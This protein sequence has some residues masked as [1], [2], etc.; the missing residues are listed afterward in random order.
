MFDELNSCVPV[1]CYDNYVLWYGR[2]RINLASLLSSYV[3][4][5]QILYLVTIV[6]VHL[7]FEGTLL[8]TVSYNLCDTVEDVLMCQFGSR[9]YFMFDDTPEVLPHGTI[10]LT[11]IYHFHTLHQRM[12]VWYN[13][14]SPV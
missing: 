5:D 13:L 1:L 3:W 11:V 9:D 8:P 4:E 12:Q 7:H 6:E 2:E 10:S 14:M